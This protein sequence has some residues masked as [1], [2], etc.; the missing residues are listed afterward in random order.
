ML[1]PS[2]K[3]FSRSSHQ[4]Q[5]GNENFFYGIRGPFLTHTNHTEQHGC[6][7]AILLHSSL[8]FSLLLTLPRMSFIPYLSINYFSVFPKINF[9]K[10]LLVSSGSSDYTFLS[11]HSV[12]KLYL[13]QS[14]VITRLQNYPYIK[15]F[16]LQDLECPHSSEFNKVPGTQ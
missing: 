3:N 14:T 15:L 10:H 2:L 5:K 16:F 9:L 12:L 1:L 11:I 8:P 4:M 13:L 6:S 7:D